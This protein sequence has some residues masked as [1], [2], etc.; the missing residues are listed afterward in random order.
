MRPP[1]RAH[2]TASSNVLKSAVWPGGGAS[3]GTAA[4]SAPQHYVLTQF[5]ML[6]TWLQR[7]DRFAR[8]VERTKG[9]R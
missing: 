3:T 7:L 6:R 1:Q 4:V 8:I 9:D 2:S 5:V